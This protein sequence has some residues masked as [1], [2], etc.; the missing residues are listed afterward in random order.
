MVPFFVLFTVLF[1]RVLGKKN[2]QRETRT[3]NLPV[4]S[5]ARCRLRHPGI[6]AQAGYS[7]VKSSAPSGFVSVSQSQVLVQVTTPLLH[8][9][10]M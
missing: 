7:D 8:H 4:N 9:M 3:L 5:R 6:D 2:S 10:G 1:T